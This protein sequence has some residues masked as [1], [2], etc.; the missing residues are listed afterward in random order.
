MR[1]LGDDEV[2]H[3]VSQSDGEE[4]QLRR[5]I[6]VKLEC[7]GSDA[8]RSV[9]RDE[10][11]LHRSIVNTELTV[12]SLNIE[13]DGAAAVGDRHAVVRGIRISGDIVRE[14]WKTILEA[15]GVKADR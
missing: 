5:E 4:L 1:R 2:G 12:G 15:V 9:E 7:V 11:A 10:P 13:P 14:R 6:D 8:R 3:E